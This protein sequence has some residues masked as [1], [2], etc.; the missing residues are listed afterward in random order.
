[1]MIMC[2]LVFLENFQ[3]PPSGRWTAT[4]RT[5]AF[6]DGLW[7]LA[8]NRLAASNVLLGDTSLCTQFFWFYW[9]ARRREPI[10]VRFW[11]FW[12]SRMTLIEEKWNSYMYW[13]LRI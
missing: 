5:H 6:V 13:L 8:R 4:R 12:G 11:C 9:I 10:L 7:V 3:K 1:M 2:K